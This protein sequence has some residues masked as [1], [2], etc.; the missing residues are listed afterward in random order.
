[1]GERLALK[2]SYGGTQ[3]PKGFKPVKDRYRE[4]AEFLETHKSEFFTLMPEEFGIQGE[5]KRK[6]KQ[7]KYGVCVVNTLGCEQYYTLTPQKYFCHFCIEEIKDG[8][9]WTLTEYDGAEGIQYFKI[10]PGSY[11]LE[12]VIE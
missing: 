7:N 8:L 4:L 6:I 12:K 10:K 3:W 2:S 11:Q 1:M 5:L 9:Y